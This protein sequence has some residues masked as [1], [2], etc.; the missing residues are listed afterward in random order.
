MCVEERGKGDGREWEVLI[1][2]GCGGLSSVGGAEVIVG[3][4]AG[5]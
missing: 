5:R 2:D 3:K 1:G 4:E